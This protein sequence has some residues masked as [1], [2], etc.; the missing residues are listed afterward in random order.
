MVDPVLKWAGGKRGLLKEIKNIFPKQYKNYH[1]PFIGGGAMFFHLTPVNGSIN[2]INPDLI[3]FYKILKNYPSELIKHTSRL[4]HNVE[5]YYIVRAGFNELKTGVKKAAFFLYLNR[6]GFNGL[7]RV[8]K[9]G[10]FN[11]PFGKYKNPTIVDE[12]RILSASHALN[13]TKIYNEDFEYILDVA[14]KDDLVYFDPP[15]EP[16][17]DTSN[18]TAYSKS[19]FTIEDQKRLSKTCKILDDAGV[20]FILSNSHVDR[21]IQLYEEF[22]IYTVKARRAINSDASKRGAV[23]EILVTNIPQRERVE[24]LNQST[25]DE[26]VH[27]RRVSTE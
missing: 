26:L 15:Y 22:H 25:F 4:D 19:G 2:D 17:S 14:K 24:K 8:N 9:K 3:N 5:V 18:F 27:L 16:M 20:N 13:Q 7:Y 23:N 11:V 10:E 21:I 6:T 1:E 12:K